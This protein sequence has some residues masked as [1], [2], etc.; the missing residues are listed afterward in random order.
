MASSSPTFK[1][2]CGA[3]S[4]PNKGGKYCIMCAAARP[5]RQAV[6]AAPAPNM[7]AANACVPA[8]S[9]HP[10]GINLD[11]VGIACTNRGRSCEEHTCCGDILENDVLDKLRHEQI[12]VPD[13]IARGGKMKEETAITINQVSDSIDCCHVGFLPRAFFVQGSV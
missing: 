2:E 4:A 12:L 8:T 7:A 1:W 9:R 10:S 13:A 6:A 5:K 11:V 3:C